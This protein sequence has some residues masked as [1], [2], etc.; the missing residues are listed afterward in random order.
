MSS[1]VLRKLK[2][3]IDQKDIG[4]VK[5]LKIKD[6]G[7]EVEEEEEEIENQTYVNKFNFVSFFL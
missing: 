4:N 2:K 7:E 5:D 3:T 6:D 1:R